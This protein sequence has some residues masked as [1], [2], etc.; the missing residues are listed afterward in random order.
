MSRRLARR[1][2]LQ[3]LYQIDLTKCSTAD[4]LANTA[5]ETPLSSVDQEFAHLLVKGVRER[6][7]ELDELIARFAKDWTLERMSVVDRNILRLA[8]FE[9]RYMPDVPTKVSI[10][11][12]V[13]LAKAFSDEQAAK[14]INGILGTVVDYL[15]GVHNE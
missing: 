11:E 6:L 4:A 5:V 14:F 12:A 10:N 9:L 7:Q 2:A 1:T 15:A 13:E 3:L 8:I